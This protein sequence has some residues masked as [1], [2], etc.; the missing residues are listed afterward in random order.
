MKK[1]A[2]SGDLQAAII[3][4]QSVYIVTSFHPWL[5]IQSSAPKIALASANSADGV[6]KEIPLDQ[7]FLKPLL[8]C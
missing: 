8:V 2:F 7:Q 1:C 6:L 4:R 3:V 5:R